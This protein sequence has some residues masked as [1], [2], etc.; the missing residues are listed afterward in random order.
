MIHIKRFLIGL[1]AVGIFIALLTGLMLYTAQILA[2]I[3][4][5]MFLCVVYALGTSILNS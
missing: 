2:V 3:V 1:L 4:I 5:I